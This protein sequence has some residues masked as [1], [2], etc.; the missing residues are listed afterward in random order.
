MLA[1]MLGVPVWLGADDP[2]GDPVPVRVL[3]RVGLFEGVTEAVCR[4]A[5]QRKGEAGR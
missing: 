1:V 4:Q 2:E 5:R 3:D